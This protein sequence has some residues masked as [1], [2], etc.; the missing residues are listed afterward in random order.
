MRQDPEALWWSGS[1]RGSTVK[2]AKKEGKGLV[3]TLLAR[4][5]AWHEGPS[6]GRRVSL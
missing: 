5:K 1:V 3:G 2:A 6:M 4:V